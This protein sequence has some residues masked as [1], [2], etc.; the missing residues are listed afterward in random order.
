MIYNLK[1]ISQNII[2]P[3]HLKCTSLSC[4][5]PFFHS[6]ETHTCSYCDGRHIETSC[7]NATV[8]STDENEIKRVINEA[9]NKFGSRDGKIFTKIYCGQGCDWYA[10]RKGRNNPIQLYF[11][12]GDSWGQF[13]PQCDDRPK[14]N[15]FCQG[16]TDVDT[17]QLYQTQ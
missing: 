5:A 4:A 13:G 8:I 17:N 12:H 9:K 6:S 3:K 10:K 1:L 2:F 15:K 11:M 14:L 16:F 7:K